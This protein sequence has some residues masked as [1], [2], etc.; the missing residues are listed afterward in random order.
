M[1]AKSQMRAVAAPRASPVRLVASRARPTR[2][3]QVNAEISY[4]MV[5]N[6]IRDGHTVADQSEVDAHHVACILP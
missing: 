5:S 4:V 2:A 3:V 6:S 1:L